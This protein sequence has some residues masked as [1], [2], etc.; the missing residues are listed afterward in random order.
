MAIGH[1]LV[2]GV[3]QRFVFGMIG[4]VELKALR[5]HATA[6]RFPKRFATNPDRPGLHHLVGTEAIQVR[7]GDLTYKL[8]Q[9]IVG[10]VSEG[11]NVS[12][13]S[14]DVAAITLVLFGQALH[15][16]LVFDLNLILLAGFV[17]AELAPAEPARRLLPAACGI[18]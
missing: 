8:S 4:E 3:E 18:A 6:D 15:P 17:D 5:L 14:L 2:P 11:L 9:G 1:V 13:V 16:A 10:L 12:Q 7:E